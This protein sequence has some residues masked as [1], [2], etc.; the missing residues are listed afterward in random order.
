MS[1]NLQGNLAC[2]HNRDLTVAP[3]PAGV[4]RLINRRQLARVDQGYCP[5]RQFGSRAAVR[6][7]IFP[8]DSHD[9]H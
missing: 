4:N 8:I 6:V 2:V 5:I 9:I 1:H 7:R 3:W